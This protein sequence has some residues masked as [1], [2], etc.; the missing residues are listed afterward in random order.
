VKRAILAAALVL[1]AAVLVSWMARRAPEPRAP[2][3]VLL[4][5]IDT[6]RA[7]RV[8][9]YGGDPALTPN[10]DAL[11]RQGAVFEEALA[12]VPLTL[13]SHATILSGLEPTHH[14]VH[15]NGTYVFPSDR[16][17]LATLLKGRGYATGA[18]V[19][20]YVLDRRF[21]LARGFDL[22]DDAIER[23]TEGVSL[24]ESERRCDRVAAA[25]GEWVTKQGG[26][27]LAWAHFYDPHA[28]YDPPAPYRESFPSRAYDGEVAYADACV[29]TLIDAARRKAGD[30]LIVAVLADHGE[31]LGA[32]GESTHGFFLYQPTLRIPMILA[33]PGVPGGVRLPGLARTADLLPTLLRLLDVPAPPGL[34]SVD[35]LGG[36]RARE[37]YAETVY[38]QTLGWAPLHSYR[39]GPLK[40]VHAPR[41]ELY[42]LGLD[43]GEEHDLAATR[44]AEVARLSAALAAMRRGETTA[45][46][47]ASDPEVAERLR[48]LGYVTGPPSTG[49]AIA[50]S[51]PKDRIG[52]W[53]RFEE[54]TWADARGERVK[55]LNAFRALVAEEP[56]NATFRRTHAA[57]LR[58]AGRARDAAAALGDLEVFAADDPLAWHEA[59]VVAAED[60]RLDDAIRAERRALLLGPELPELHNHLGILLARTGSAVEALAS[61]ARAVEIDPNNAPAWTNR[62][63][64]LRALGR[65]PEAGVAYATAVRLAPRDPDPRNGLGVLAVE[66]GDLEG[67]AALFREVLAEN[68]AFH[69]ARLNLAVVYVRQQRLA[70]ARGELQAILAARPDRE[71]AARAAAFLR[72]LS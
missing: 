58:R 28:P 42:D 32:H 31:A 66:K 51:D 6:L 44:P 11:A 15:D 63:N 16:E 18:F 4:V 24:L 17:T 20:A 34:D 36:P 35:V 5:T 39:I 23:R 56:A 55:A 37:S 45:P 62:G 43:P 27:F 65:G 72:D 13:P 61:F 19:G 3:S 52:L 40:Y 2:R 46:R 60:G 29:G 67:A 41:P 33:G 53:H 47:S 30:G 54:A 50:L 64:A 69:E 59:A 26:P 71:T 38:P 57:A 12:S 10:I 25:A 14:G 9:A 68:A 21:G 70:E 49:A 8:G 48:G 7:D 22:Y 1:G